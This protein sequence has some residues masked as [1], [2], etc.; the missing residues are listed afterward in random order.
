MARF[1]WECSELP[2]AVGYLLFRHHD[3]WKVVL[4]MDSLSVGVQ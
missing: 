1:P 3:E 2:R 4:G